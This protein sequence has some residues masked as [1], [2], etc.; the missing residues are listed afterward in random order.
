MSFQLILPELNIP[1][2]RI[3]LSART[4]CR[5]T[6]VSVRAYKFIVVGLI[7]ISILFAWRWW[8]LQGQTVSFDFIEK[9]CM[10]TQDMIDHP[11][12]GLVPEGLALRLEFLMGY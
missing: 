2:L 7:C 9:Q 10:I 11:P 3:L 1:T 4:P 6:A 12:D 5:I 8:D